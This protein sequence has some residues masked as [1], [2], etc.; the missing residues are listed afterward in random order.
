MGISFLDNENFSNYFSAQ[1]IKMMARIKKLLMLNFL[2]IV[3]SVTAQDVPYLRY[4][5]FTTTPIASFN[6]VSIHYVKL[7]LDDSDNPHVLFRIQEGSNYT[8]Y[9]THKENGGFVEPMP[10]ISLPNKESE[11]LAVLDHQAI[12]H[13]V[14]G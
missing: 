5:D 8:F 1:E 10:V 11:I 4:D 3:F 13:I 7:Q 2:L 12:W 9:A 14:Y 6:D